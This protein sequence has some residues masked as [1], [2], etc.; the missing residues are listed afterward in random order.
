[1]S[2][3]WYLRNPLVHA[4]RQPSAEDSDWIRSF[5]CSMMKPLIICRG[6]I[7]MEAMCV[8]EEMGI[9]GYGILLSEK[10][11]I[12]YPN[13]LSPELRKNI[14][15]SHVHRV[16]DYSGATG[17][18][19]TER[20]AQIIAIARSH[21]YDSIFAGYGFMAEDE[22]MVAAMEEAGLNFIGPCASTIKGAGRKDLAKRTALQ[23]GVSVTPGVDN[24][25]ILTL[26]SL[27]GDEINL[28]ALIEQH[29]LDVNEADLAGCENLEQM[30]EAILNAAYD[31]HIDLFSI[32]DLANTLTD[33]VR[34]LFRANPDNRIRLKAIGGGGGKGQRILDCPSR[35]EGSAREQLEQAVKPT[36]SLLLEVL[37]EIK[38]TGVGDNK[39]VLAEV[40]IETVRHE[41]IQVVGNGDWCIT[42]GGRDCS[43]Q[44]NEQK[45]F[46]ISVTVEELNEAIT[47]ANAN[48]Q[49]EAAA[50]LQSDLKILMEL[51]DEAAK[52]GAA[53]GLDSVSTFESIVDG[54]RHFFMEM[55]TRVQVEH[56]VTELCYRLRFVN[57]DNPDDSFEVES[58][59]ELM[60]LLAEHGKRLPRPTR[61][62]RE[63]SA[64]EVR[65]NATDHSL[66]PHAGGII[67]Y[68][69]NTHE[70][71]IRDDQGICLHNP[72][73]DVFMKYHLAGAYDSN[74]ALIL[75]TGVNRQESFARMAEI[76]RHMRLAGDNLATNLE[77]HYGLVNWLI[78][79]GVNARPATNFVSPY[80]TAVGQLKKRANQ[81]DI[82]EAYS[83]IGQFHLGRE[84]DADTR[85]A[86]EDILSQKTSL[87]ARALNKMLEQ[88]HFL[89][90][91]L[92]LNQQHFKI[93]DDGIEWLTNPVL[94][95]SELYHYLN[96]DAGNGMPALYTIW[97]H[98]RQLLERSLAFY[99]EL[100]ARFDCKD[101]PALRR[102]L[103][104]EEAEAVL[105]EA[106]GDVLGAH[107]GFQMGIEI[108]SI[109]P[110]IGHISGFF[111]LKVKPDL[112]I[113]IPQ[114][115]LDVDLRRTSLRELSPPPVAAA[116]EITTPSGGMYYAREAP[117]RE[118][119]VVEGQHFEEGDPLFIVEVMKMF[120]KVHATFAGTVDESLIDVDATIVKKGQVI[121]RVTPDEV[122][123]EEPEG[124]L[125]QQIVES[126]DRFLEFI[127]YN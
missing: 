19:R 84:T 78:G 28:Q 35:F 43:L 6:P 10:D 107:R 123:I 51:E 74:I 79:N 120:N 47:A 58:I 104:S 98:D 112:N 125:R 12:T 61:Q 18:E 108:L 49:V 118:P 15:P 86:I 85:S 11:S 96:M 8:F 117:D 82:V 91:W 106:F 30:A 77:F 45:L 25:T 69:S 64:L 121:L 90:G 92:A 93:S 83:Q 67:N 59:V 5:S 3:Q 41:E 127:Q 17:E 113:E 33:Q 80:L 32:E 72:D 66:K 14:R 29:S 71:E 55:N 57:P 9:T 2:N 126:T 4:N 20:I 46:E 56:R 38:A 27:H 95:L 31:K 124:Q 111:E 100:E 119:F 39:N 1:M 122:I 54:E 60:V 44:M 110:Y 34:E 73:T 65:L 70:N 116:D 36:Q 68:W 52:F 42:M 76:L 81:L 37:S 94:V 109:L 99:Q 101:W 115:L 103:E 87:L 22:G 62:R 40:N 89:S 75:T 48:N 16:Q 23:V 105:G 53:V 88:P 21:G 97:D 63:S 114:R 13:A 26:L 7:R 24:A 102:N 50:T